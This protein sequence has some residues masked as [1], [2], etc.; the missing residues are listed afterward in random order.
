MSFRLRNV[1]LFALVALGSCLYFLAV[2]R[3]CRVVENSATAV[4][5]PT[6]SRER[7]RRKPVAVVVAPPLTQN[8][9]DSESSVASDLA[10][11]RSFYNQTNPPTVAVAVAD[12]VVESP[13]VFP[14]AKP[15]APLEASAQFSVWA[16][17]PVGSWS[18]L[19][20]ATQTTENGK[21]V[22]SVTET[23]ATL[24]SVDFEKKRYALRYDSTIK[25]GDVDHQKNAEIVEYNFWDLVAV[26]DEREEDG[27]AA[28]LAIG[29]RVAPC[30][31]KRLTR[32]SDRARETVVI[33]NSPISEPGA[34]QRETTR[35]SVDAAGKTVVSR[36]LFVAKKAIPATPLAPATRE[37]AFSKS[38]AGRE[39][40]GASVYSA[41]VPG[42]LTREIAVEVDSNGEESLRSKTTLLDYY[43]AGA[44]ARATD[45]DIRRRPRR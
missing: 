18:R 9:P 40:T 41:A 42:G 45:P 21:T 29:D 12:D 16:R 44:S 35:S 39:T 2:E 30:R 14:L 27:P 17:F 25:M 33:W 15:D 38:V 32:E 19:R 10:R 7:A 6:P 43:V 26:D 13:D 31:V 1:A 5:A 8:A 3:D 34:L 4:E 37:A 20:V 24:V 28:N 36:E 22:E 23:R 11:S